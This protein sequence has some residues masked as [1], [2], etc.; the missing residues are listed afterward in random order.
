MT[1][2][3]RQSPGNNLTAGSSKSFSKPLKQENA[4]DRA[5]VRDLK[6]GRG[7]RRWRRRKR[8]DETTLSSHT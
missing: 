2:D 8:K 1:I 3:L 6:E 4:V 7:K 5:I